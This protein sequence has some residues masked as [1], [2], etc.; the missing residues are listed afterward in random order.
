ALPCRAQHGGALL[1]PLEKPPTKSATKAPTKASAKPPSK[2]AQSTAKD[3][4]DPDESGKPKKAAR[5]SRIK[6][7]D[8][9]AKKKKKRNKKPNKKAG[10]QDTPCDSDDK[11]AKCSVGQVNGVFLIKF[12]MQDYLWGVQKA[13]SAEKKTMLPEISGCRNVTYKFFLFEPKFRG[14]PPTV[15]RFSADNPCVCKIIS[16]LLRLLELGKEREACVSKTTQCKLVLIPGLV[17]PCRCSDLSVPP[18]LSG[19]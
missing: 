1:L 16:S 6:N 19:A 9:K 5:K 4:D 2:V 15:T 18:L 12:P 8:K 13:Q 17:Q 14:V 3:L 11:D 10:Q 7:N